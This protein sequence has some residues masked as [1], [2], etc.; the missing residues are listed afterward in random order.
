MAICNKC[1]ANVTDEVKFCPQCG[2]EIVASPA[3]E[4]VNTEEKE[5]F[6]DKVKGIN[7]T[8]DTTAD[9]EAKDI[10]DNKTISFLS[11]LGPLFLCLCLPE[12]AQSSH[13]FTQIRAW[14]SL[15]PT[16]LML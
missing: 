2:A 9:F 1:G 15:L 5:S 13:V 12:N 3:Q 7:D 11:Y 10:Q 6:A 16:R 4:N 14:C 8:P